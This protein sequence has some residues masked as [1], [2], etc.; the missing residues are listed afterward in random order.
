MDKSGG[1]IAWAAECLTSKFAD[2][3]VPEEFKASFGIAGIPWDVLVDHGTLRLPTKRLR[4]IFADVTPHPN[5]ARFSLP[6]AFLPSEELGP[7]RITYPEG[8]GKLD[9]GHIPENI[10]DILSDENRCLVF[11]ERYGSFLPVS[12]ED[13]YRHISFYDFVKSAAAI[14]SCLSEPNKRDVHKPFLL[15]SADFSGIQN[16]VYTISSKGA[17]KTLRA[18]SFMLEML[19]EH[20]IYEILTN[21]ENTSRCNVIYAGGGGFALG[22]C[23]GTNIFVYKVC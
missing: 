14:Q 7:E 5:G 3:R 21:G 22:V 16:F 19:T 15:V 12:D 4:S 17:L 10:T 11:L 9:L 8:D 6:D 20:V 23:R 18:R 2:I 1:I 13:E